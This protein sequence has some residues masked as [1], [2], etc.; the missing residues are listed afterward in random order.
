MFTHFAP[1]HIYKSTNCFTLFYENFRFGYGCYIKVELGVEFR[2]VK[3][4]FTL[5]PLEYPRRSF[6]TT[7]D[8]ASISLS[9][10]P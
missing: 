6:A 1:K 3:F 2:K 9:M 5:T 4:C 10:A 8:R 7:F